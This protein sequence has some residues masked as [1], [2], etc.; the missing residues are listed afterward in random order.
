MRGIAAGPAGDQLDQFATNQFEF[1]RSLEQYGPAVSIDLGG[2]ETV[3]LYDIPA[4]HKLLADKFDHVDM[5]L[6]SRRLEVVTGTGLLTNFDWNVWSPR[7]RI[8]FRPIGARA[9]GN[10]VERMT[11]LIEE[12]LDTWPLGVPFELEHAV[13]DM[14]LRVVADLLF[15][16]DITDEA[17]AV[18]GR[19]VDELHRW[20]EADPTNANVTDPPES[21]REAL[22]EADSYIRSVI[23]ARSPDAPVDD[24]L[25]VLLAAVDDE[26]VPIDLQGVRDELITMVLAGHETVTALICFAIDLVGRHPETADADRRHIVDETLRLYPPVH[27]LPRF[28]RED[29]DV[30]VCELPAGTEVFIPMIQLFRDERYFERADEFLPERWDPDSPLHMERRAYF[31]FITGP[32]LCV[33]SHYALMEGTIA[34][35]RFLAKFDFELLEPATPWGREFALT[36]LPDKPQSIVLERRA[37]E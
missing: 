12:R 24:L 30:G 4:I 16:E 13:S 20:S 37:A 9:V 27:F 17:I 35:D 28:V 26:G 1:I 6:L 7:R 32:K 36:F 8:I 31:P 5:P 14:T 2:T 11:T 25:G 21:F 33:G 10:F 34:L 15:S 18:I 23:D 3:W 22:E 19:I 29:F